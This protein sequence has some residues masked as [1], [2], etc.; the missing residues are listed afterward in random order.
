VNNLATSLAQQPVQSP[1]TVQ[2]APEKPDQQQP[3]APNR[4]MLLASA[5]S[6]AL[7]ALV[8]AQKV[9][10]E[11]RTEECD[12][13]CAVAMCNLGDIAAMAGDVAEAKRRFQESLEL[14][15]KI[16]FQPGIVHAKEGLKRISAPS[17][18]K[19]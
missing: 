7:Q 16:A 8:T 17:P 4:T 9:T 14:S 19:T 18:S 12:E 6:W 15:K 5:R 13:A 2:A 10:G 1:F 11:A 3:Q